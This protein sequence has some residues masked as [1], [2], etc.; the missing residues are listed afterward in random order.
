VRICTFSVSKRQP[1]EGTRRRFALQIGSARP[2]SAAAAAFNFFAFRL[3][4]I[5][6]AP[7][8]ILL[9]SF[10]AQLR[11]AASLTPHKSA[12]RAHGAFQ[13]R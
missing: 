7:V 8:R 13:L 11:F 3:S 6:A 10:A 12:H 4:L 9:P 2:S 1:P 5:N